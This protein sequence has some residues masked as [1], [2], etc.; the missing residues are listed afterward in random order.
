M[1]RSTALL[2]CMIAA[3]ALVPH[4]AT[5]QDMAVTAGDHVKVLLDNEHARVLEL[6]MPPGGKTGMH[7][8]GDN[9]VHFLTAG[10]TTQTGADGTVTK[11]QRKAGET[12]WSGPATHDTH[13]TGKTSMKVLVIELK[14]P[15]P[16]P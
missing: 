8:H 14:A 16:K 6:Q 15:A 7:A 10:E 3:S 1:D 4:A 9:I 13:N 2:A 12:L 11:V 5:A